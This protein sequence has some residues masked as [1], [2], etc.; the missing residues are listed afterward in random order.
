[1]LYSYFL[2]LHLVVLYDISYNIVI[3][4]NVN[5]IINITSVYSEYILAK[6]HVNYDIIN[7]IQAI[8]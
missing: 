8:L 7:K 4:K 6:V 2:N 1:M 3:R 5:D